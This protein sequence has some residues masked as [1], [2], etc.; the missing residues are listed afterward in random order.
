MAESKII[1]LLLGAAGAGK[2]EIVHDLVTTGLTTG[3]KAHLL[4]PENTAP[5][6]HPDAAAWPETATTTTWRFQDGML[7]AEIPA[8]ATHVFFLADGRADPADQVE[9]FAAWLGEQE[10]ELGQIV[11]V[12]HCQ[13]AHAHTKLMHWHEA[14]IHFSDMVLLNRRA[15]VP[16]K[17][18]NGFVD[19]FK[20]LH[21][22]CLFEFVK[23]GRVANPALVLTPQARRISLIFDDM[24]ALDETADA[25]LGDDEDEDPYLART[26]GGKRARELPDIRKMMD[27][28]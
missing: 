24:P 10:A 22:P 15:D 23:N 7:N 1:Y 19:H 9:K 16:Q 27:G 6:E 2:R 14:C 21:Y 26:A 17:W 3:D 20:K 5:S 4:V 11:T 13:L 28:D 12:V 18:I 8:E 25:D